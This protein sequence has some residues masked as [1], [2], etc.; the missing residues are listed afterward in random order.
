MGL[1]TS[2]K[3]LAN[4]TGLPFVQPGPPVLHGGIRV[5][6]FRTEGLK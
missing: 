5:T 1:I 6:L 4:A 2:D 3:G